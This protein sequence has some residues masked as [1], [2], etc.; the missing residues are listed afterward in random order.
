MKS[1]RENAKGRRREKEN[2]QLEAGA[3]TAVSV[4]GTHDRKRWE[5]QTDA[6][7]ADASNF[8]DLRLAASTRG[9]LLPFS[10]L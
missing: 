2:G 6:N 8:N 3:K 5:P 1:N 4:H 9:F 10:G 7:G